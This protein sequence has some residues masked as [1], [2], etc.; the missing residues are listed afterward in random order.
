MPKQIL[1]S[2]GAMQINKYVPAWLKDSS[3]IK[4]D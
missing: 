1:I 3:I 4:S 2:T